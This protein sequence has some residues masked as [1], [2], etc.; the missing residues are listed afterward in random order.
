VKVSAAGMERRKAISN[1]RFSDFKC[2]AKA[3][4]P[5]GCVSR[6]RASRRYIKDW[7]AGATGEKAAKLGG[8]DSMDGPCALPELESV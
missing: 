4:E 3:K 8:P 6:L 2:K 1:L 7:R 5:A